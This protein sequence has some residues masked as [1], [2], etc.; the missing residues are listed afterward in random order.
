MTKFRGFIAIDINPFTKLI[1]F[2]R[3][4]KN[5]GA[6]VKLVEPKNIHLTLKFLGD[7]DE[8]LI[9][10][11]D[12]ILKDS[13]REIESFSIRL[14]STGV[15]PNERYIKVMWI[16]IE[17]S[18]IIGKIAENIN[19]KLS[20]LGFKKE[21][22]KFSAHLTIARVKNAKNKDKLIQIIEKYRDV[23]FAYFKVDSIKLKKSD[24]TPKG[25]IY[26]TLKEIK[27]LKKT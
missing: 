14:K 27:F 13:V 6:N 21:K 26:T 24:L 16:G 8:S 20:N 15:F 9:E 23:E 18:E 11:I 10:R 17:N 25:P 3:E 7:T 1:E 19:E 4:I 2:E 5:S 22:R 12:E